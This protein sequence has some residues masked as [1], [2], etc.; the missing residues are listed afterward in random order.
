MKE[1]HRAKAR[2]LTRRWNEVTQKKVSE[3]T[4]RRQMYSLGYNGRQARE[5]P[6]ISSKNKNGIGQTD[7]KKNLG[8]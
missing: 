6:Y 4:T 8:Y 7:D 5:K 3:M 1:D 2:I